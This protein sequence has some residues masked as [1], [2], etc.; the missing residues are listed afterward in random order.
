MKI[1]KLQFYSH[2]PISFSNKTILNRTK[3]EEIIELYKSGKTYQQIAYMFNCANSTVNNL[4]NNHPDSIEIKKEHY[5]NY[6]KPLYINPQERKVIINLYKTTNITQAQ[7]AELYNCSTDCIR[8]ILK[9]E[10]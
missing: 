4:I 8:N 2:N 10:I 9:T 5:K 3:K 1:T 7:L 6:E